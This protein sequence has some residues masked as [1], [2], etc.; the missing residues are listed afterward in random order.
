MINWFKKYWVV[1]ILGIIAFLPF[2]FT[3]FN[4]FVSDDWDFLY[5]AAHKGFSISEIFSTNNEGNF[6]G[7]SYRPLVVIFWRG[8][9]QLVGLHP[10]AYHLA[11]TAFHV[12]NVLLLYFL[13]KKIFGKFS[14]SGRIASIAA[15]LFAISPSRG[16]LAWI[17]VVNDSLV[18]LFILLTLHTFFVSLEARTNVKR[19]GFFVLSIVTTFLAFL[20]KEAALIIPP[21]IFMLALGY[22]RVIQQKFFLRLIRSLVIT[23]PYLFV[24][25][26]F[27]AL[28]YH[29]IGLLFADYTGEVKLTL[30]HVIR[31]LVSYTFGFFFLGS[32]RTMIS[33][34]FIKH[35]VLF[36]LF[37]CVSVG[38]IFYLFRKTKIF[39]TTLCAFGLYLIS[40]IPVIRFAINVTPEYI[41][42]EG[43]RY[44]YLPSIFLCFCIAVFISH[45][46]GSMTK[47]QRTYFLVMGIVCSVALYSQLFCTIHIWN[48]ASRLADNLLHQVATIVEKGEY[49]GYVVVGLPDQYQG[50]PVFRNVFERALS[51]TL[52]DPSLPFSSLIVTRNRT[53]YDPNDMF[54]VSRTHEN[55][56]EYRSLHNLPRVSSVPEF[57]SSDYVTTLIE[58]KRLPEAVSVFDV[59]SGLSLAFSSSFVEHNVEVH[60]QIG[61]LFFTSPSWSV[62]PLSS[63]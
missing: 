4:P 20:T 51:L 14:D 60:N 17:S 5:S 46:Y 23:L 21:T 45:W 43:Q 53:L 6:T 10:F 27:F 11:T 2:S 30:W 16:E 29:V 40:L 56:F 52:T 13:I 36:I 3:L 1:I 24:V 48:R 42:D 34:F 18:V 22:G 28:R 33:Y 9:Y 37:A 32:I 8:L 35:F 31:S 19:Y 50:A 15:F 44:I 12:T 57:I 39:I 58:H 62:V 54:V 26:L 59:G 7:G 38:G 49:D 55:S 47:R 41:S 25:V 63:K 61:I